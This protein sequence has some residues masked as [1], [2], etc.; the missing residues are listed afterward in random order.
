[1][2]VVMMKGV[3]EATHSTKATVKGVT[4]RASFYND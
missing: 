1:M 2:H 3:Q 4:F